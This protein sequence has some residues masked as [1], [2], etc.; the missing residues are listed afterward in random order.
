MKDLKLAFFRFIFIY[1]KKTLPHVPRVLLPISAIKIALLAIIINPK[2]FFLGIRNVRKHL[3]LEFSLSLIIVLKSYYNLACTLIEFI[4][5]PSLS[6]DFIKN[7]CTVK[8]LD[9]LKNAL[10]KKNGVLLL[11]AHFGNWEYLG[12]FLVCSN[13]PL[14]SIA[15]TQKDPKMDKQINDIRASHGMEV[16]T[17]GFGLRQAVAALKKNRII[18]IL[19]DQDAKDQGIFIDFLG[20]QA[21]TPTT[22]SKLHKKYSSPIV[23][24]F[25]KRKKILEFEIIV[26][27]IIQA[28]KE[29]EKDILKL[30]N[31]ITSKNI[32]SA[33][34]QWLWM[35]NRW[36]SKKH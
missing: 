19:N 28:Y 5:I 35:H 23:P 17:K 12:Q 3:S 18:G 7:S 21:S 14:S 8:N 36:R 22:I 32:L 24:V 30:C 34:E 31:D 2:R 15:K 6:D 9:N 13:L 10:D 29:S 27:P 4:L 20:E 11:T 26:Y 1:L 33:P 16:I 25:I